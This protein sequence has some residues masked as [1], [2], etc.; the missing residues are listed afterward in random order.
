MSMIKFS[1]AAFAILLMISTNSF[2]N[3]SN[4]NRIFQEV[5]SIY[6]SMQT[7]KAHGTISTD[8]D[9][10]GMTMKTQTE[11]SMILMK[12]NRYRITWNQKGM[13]MPGMAQAGA[14]W[15]DGTQPYMYMGVM[16]AYSK[17][18]SDE[19]ALGS[20][21]GLSG[22]AATTIP[23][24][25]FSLFN[26]GSSP[27]SRLRNPK[28]EKIEKVDND[29]CY[30]ISGSSTISKKET[31]W[32]S[33]SRHLIIKVYRSL[34][35]PQGGRKMPVLTDEQLEE[36][37]R[38]MGLKVTDESKQNVRA[39]MTRSRD[40]LNTVTVKGF[41]VE[42][43]HNISSPRMTKNDFQYAPPEDAVLRESLFKNFFERGDGANTS[44]SSD[45]GTINANDVPV[46]SEMSTTSKTVKFFKK[47]Q[48]VNIAIEIEG[49][50]D[51]WCGIKEDGNKAIEGYVQ[52]KYL[53]RAEAK[54]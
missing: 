48:V 8:V 41:T 28:L 19:I 22:G 29:A 45:G 5:V 3:E 49:S 39:L 43:H 25:F 32:I 33:K 46:Y 42:L 35:S 54:Q 52:C 17:M 50:E 16:N 12:P 37:I 7:Y 2:A 36:A 9:T 14:V 44:K 1:V 30:V 15:S 11:F 38:S 47:G 18:A 40:I 26:G 53:E 6:K 20:A 10:N 27:F 34:E 4:P 31:Y 51:S 21:T 13:P 24:L 23:S